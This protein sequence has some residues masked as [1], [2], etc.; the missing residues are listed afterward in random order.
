MEKSLLSI[1]N[2]EDLIVRNI[3]SALD[4]IDYFTADRERISR[5][6]F[7]CEARKSDIDSCDRLISKYREDVEEYKQQLE[8]V[9]K[10]LREYLE[11]ILN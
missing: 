10:E 3:N 6:P 8:S 4:S 1:L 7:E 11:A 9:R 2:A 5:S